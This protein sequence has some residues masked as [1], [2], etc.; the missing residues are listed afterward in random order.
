MTLSCTRDNKLDTWS[1]LFCGSSR[2]LFCSSSSFKS[3][4]EATF[5]AF[6]VPSL[7]DENCRFYVCVFCFFWTNIGQR[8]LETREI[9]P[10]CTRSLQ[11]CTGG[12]ASRRSSKVKLRFLFFLLEAAFVSAH[13]QLMP[14]DRRLHLLLSDWTHM[15]FGET[16]RCPS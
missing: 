2:S 6:Q 15:S 8:C 11:I 13:W 4:L 5:L 7:N 12:K 3:Y 14:R 10:V 16:K 1:G 9:T